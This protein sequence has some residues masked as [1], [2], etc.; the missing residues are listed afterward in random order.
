MTWLFM[1]MTRDPTT[2]LP[3][4]AVAR[5]VTVPYDTAVTN[6][7]ELIVAWPVPLTIDHV[8]VLF[9]A[10]AGNTAAVNCN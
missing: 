8:T 9:V 5:A 10:S 2:P 7:V 4:L 3:S 6:P 1:E